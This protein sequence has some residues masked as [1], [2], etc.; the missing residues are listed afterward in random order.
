MADSA[1]DGASLSDGMEMCSLVRANIG[2][3]K[4]HTRSS[5]DLVGG[6]GGAGA[7]TPAHIYAVHASHLMHGDIEERGGRVYRR[8][9]VLTMF[10][11]GLRAEKRQK[12]CRGW[13]V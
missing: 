6:G 12:H 1:W 3:R 5:P 11:V 13:V 10:S 2:N 7:R 8:L 9:I 4:G